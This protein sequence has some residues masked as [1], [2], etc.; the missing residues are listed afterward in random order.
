MSAAFL[1]T[2]LIWTGLLALG[3]EALTRGRVNPRFAQSVWRIAAFLMVLPWLGLVI[4]PILPNVPAYLPDFPDLVEFGGAQNAPAIATTTPETPSRI[5]PKLADILFGTLILGWIIR[6]CFAVTAHIRL[7]ALTRA[8][9]PTKNSHF[10]IAS[11]HWAAQLKLKTPPQIAR[12]NGHGSPFVSGL[13]H[14]TIYL[15]ASLTDE[16]HIKPVIAHECTH[17]ARGDLITRP[18]ERMVADLIWFSPFA[19]LARQRLDYWREAVCD[20]ETVALTAEPIAYARALSFVARNARPMPNLPIAA[21]IPNKKKALPMRV[22]SILE[23]STKT[24]RK[25]LGLGLAALLIAAPLALAQGLS[26]SAVDSAQTFSRPIINVDGARITSEY[27]IR[28]HPITKDTSFHVG[29]D[30]AGLPLGT[31]LAAPADGTVVHAGIK[32]AH[33]GTE[34]GYGNVVDLRLNAS[35]HVLRYAQLSEVKVSKGDRVSAGNIV[36]L[37]GS[38]GQST[39]PHLH[40][41]YHRPHPNPKNPE[42]ADEPVPWNPQEVEGLVLFPTE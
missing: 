12:F 1:L 21:L 7:R 32:L 30:I 42:F 24:S 31:P 2:S 10:I 14:Q 41:E 13:L 6:A 36:G 5:T 28:T 40:L 25:R 22:S 16:T 39:G 17:I 34:T 20:A 38:S 26:E 11:V 27:G 9:T 35:G 15:P 18:L 23:P 3:A 19:W 37:L 4:S 33:D 29:T 8:A